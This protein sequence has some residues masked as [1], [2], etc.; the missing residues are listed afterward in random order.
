[1]KRRSRS[2]EGNDGAGQALA[3]DIAGL[4]FSASRWYRVFHRRVSTHAPLFLAH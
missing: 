1:V 4:L 3:E 2:I